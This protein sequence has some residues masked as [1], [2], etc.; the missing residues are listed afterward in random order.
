MSATNRGSKRKMQDNYPTPLNTIETFLNTYE[1][2]KNGVILEPCAGNGN[3]V[4]ALRNKGYKN[5]I[6]ANEIRSEETA[7]LIK[8]GADVITHEDFLE[9]DCVYDNVSTIIT[10]P[11]YSLA[12]E[13]LEKCFELYPDADIIMLLR[14]AFLESKTR[15]D[16]WQQY[17]VNKLYV[18][19]NRPKFVN[20]KTDAT[21]YAFF[22][23][24]GSDKQEIRV[25]K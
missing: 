15:Y 4:K 7:N 21:A 23:W 24:D 3:F 14:L 17:P 9:T 13:F 1:L 22:V 5:K 16:F 2:D 25:I 11:P 12:K 10:N 20:N 8:S 19:S 18:L 6:I